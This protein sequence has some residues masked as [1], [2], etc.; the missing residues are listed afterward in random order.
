MAAAS[1]PDAPDRA[2][3]LVPEVMISAGAVLCLASITAHLASGFGDPLLMA[4]HVVS[5]T[6]A[7]VVRRRRPDLPASVWFAAIAALS[8]AS[9]LIDGVLASFTADGASPARL[10]WANLVSAEVGL[11]ATLALAVAIATFPDG[12]PDTLRQRR[13]LNGLVPVLLVPLI[14]ILATPS[15]PLPAYLAADASPNPWHLLP[16]A[17]PPGGAVALTGMASLLVLVVGVGMLVVRYRRSSSGT[18]RRIRW[19]L[20]P[21]VLLGIA[22]PLNIFVIESTRLGSWVLLIVVSVSGDVAATLGILAPPRADADRVLRRTIV[23]GVLWLAIAG[24]Y[25]AAATVVGVAAGRALPVGWAVAIACVAAVLFQPARTRVE[26]LAT[27]RAFGTR[28][29]PA[30]VIARLGDSLAGTFDL[31]TLLPRMARALEEGLGLV[32]ARVRLDEGS[33]TADVAVPVRLDGEVLGVVECGPKLRGSWT[34]EDLAVVTTFAGQAALAVH[35][36]RLTEHLARRAS[37]LAASRTRLVRAQERER[38]R[39]ERNIHDGV[40]QE[41]VAII[42]L[43]GFARRQVERGGP[44]DPGWVADELGE[45]QAGMQRLL[46]DLRELAAGVHPSV[47]TDHGLPA[48]LEA[49]VTRHPVPTRLTID[50]EL[51]RRRLPEEVEG[52]AYF[53]VAEALANSLKHASAASLEVEIARSNGSLLAMVRDDGTGFVPPPPQ[54]GGLARLA[55]RAQ[56]LDGEL[57]VTS[58]PGEGTRVLARFS[59]AAHVV[60]EPV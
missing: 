31:S 16:V 17:L 22:L 13:V 34:E 14:V 56:A 1:L 44:L 54:G 6:A 8:A 48:A 46:T 24:T 32:W 53:T 37:E 29:D 10:A 3:A 49:L 25:V 21:I 28:P 35:N 23:F 38:R 12:R 30:L 60:E 26:R 33:G 18:R 7:T 2:G 51:R 41:L 55:E 45:I 59:V 20:L 47:L 27:R 11:S 9:G 43:V 19:V 50:P 4:T 5:L 57:A 40:Q 42:G 39:I 15:T 36:V 52:A 58:A